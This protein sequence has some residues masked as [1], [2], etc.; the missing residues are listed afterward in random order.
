M[1]K[2]L[3]QFCHAITDHPAIGLNLRFTGTAKKT[4]TTPL[5]LQVGP[6]ADQSARL[7]VKM[8]QFNLQPAF[9]SRGT[10]TENL[11]DQPGAVDNLDL[12]LF[13]QIALLNSRQGTVYNQNVRIVLR[14]NR[15]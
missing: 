9:R 3:P 2:I 10:C 5:P 6:A 15:P 13:F 11:Q 1:R 8:C 4:E 14:E 7:I 12:E